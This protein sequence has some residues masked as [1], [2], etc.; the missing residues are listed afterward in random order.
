[1]IKNKANAFIKNIIGGI[2]I[3]LIGLYIIIFKKQELSKEAYLISSILL[4]VVGVLT[5]ISNTIIFIY[6]K[7]NSKYL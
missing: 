3:I 5:T 2:L 4:L 1:M 6:L 7:K